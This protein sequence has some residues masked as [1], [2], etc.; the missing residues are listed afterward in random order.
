MYFKQLVKYMYGFIRSKRMHITTRGGK[1]YIGKG[2]KC[3]GKRIVLETNVCI[4]PYVSLWN[5]GEGIE[6]GAGSEIGERCRISIANHL[7]IGKKV[8]LS[9]NVYITDCDHAYEDIEKAVL[10]QGIVQ[11]RNCVEIKDGTYVGINSVIIGNVTIGIHCVI[12]AN[13]VVTRSIPDYCVAVGCPARVIKKYDMNDCK[14][15]NILEG[16]EKI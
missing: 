9:P 1:I 3:K 4:R 6:I 15:K 14:W 2:V 12:G 7:R 13:S 5:S 16:F 8:L 10:E 11:D